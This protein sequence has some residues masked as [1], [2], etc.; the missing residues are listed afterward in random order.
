LLLRHISAIRRSAP[1]AE[2]A[3]ASKGLKTTE[4]E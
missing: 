1:R 2:G 3:K 4:L